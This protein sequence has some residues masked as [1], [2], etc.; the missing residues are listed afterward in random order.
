MFKTE[1]LKQIY[2][3][4]RFLSPWVTIDIVLWDQLMVIKFYVY[5][6]VLHNQSVENESI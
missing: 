1:N 3:E 2:W 6:Q 4:T 5:S